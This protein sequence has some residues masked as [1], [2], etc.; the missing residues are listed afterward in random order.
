MH[1]INIDEIKKIGTYD[2]TKAVPSIE[3]NNDYQT[4]KAYLTKNL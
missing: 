4:W 1:F 3:L 2:E